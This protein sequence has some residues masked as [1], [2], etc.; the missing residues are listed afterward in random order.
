MR[1]LKFNGLCGGTS[2]RQQLQTS[3]HNW[4]GHEQRKVVP[5]IYYSSNLKQYHEPA[6]VRDR[7]MT[8]K[9]LTSCSLHVVH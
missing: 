5:D 6:L 7:F 8:A 1:L 9:S 3:D 2:S 4:R